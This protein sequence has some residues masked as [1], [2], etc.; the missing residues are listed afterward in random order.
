MEKPDIIIDLA[1]MTMAERQEFTVK[2]LKERLGTDNFEDL[3]KEIRE[4]IKLEPTRVCE[5]LAA[6]RNCGIA[7]FGGIAIVAHAFD[8]SPEEIIAMNTLGA[9]MLTVNDNIGVV[10]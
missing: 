5:A 1:H 8:T 9:I 7:D 10:H 6:L 2:F 4:A 3:V